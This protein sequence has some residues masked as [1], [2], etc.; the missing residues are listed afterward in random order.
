MSAPIVGDRLLHANSDVD[1][2][3]AVAR[4]YDLSPDFP[5]D[6]AFYRSRLPRAGASVLELGCGTGRV[7]LPLASAGAHVFGIDHSAAMLEV[8][9]RKRDSAGSL[10]PG[11]VA[12]LAADITDFSLDRTFDLIIA[13][14]RVM[15]NLATDRELDGFFSRIHEH[16]HAGTR[17]IINA[18][19]PNRPPDELV[20]TWQSNEEQ[21]AW[22]VPFE[23][24]YCERYDRRTAV[25]LNP[26]VL[27]PDLIY[28]LRVD[29]RI[30]EQHVLSIAMR[31]H[32]PDD[33]LALVG[34][35]GFGVVAKWGGYSGEEYGAGGELV[36]EMIPARHDSSAGS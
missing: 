8:L 13:P 17:V 30:V 16:A 32:Y 18:F 29:D 22:R 31:C 28:R 2:R 6:V 7:T 23:G 34:R 36:V 21:M 10:S 3:A 11:S 1:T 25:T 19:H 4:F 9:E 35:H 15:Q 24:G 14:F 27:H 20:K 26:L 5:D 12:T 33:L